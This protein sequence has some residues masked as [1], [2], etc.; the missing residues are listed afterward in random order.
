MLCA[1]WP[2][3]VQRLFPLPLTW[4]Y[5]WSCH[6]PRS[7]APFHRRGGTCTPLASN[8]H[9]STTS[10]SVLAR[11]S[12]SQGTNASPTHSGLPNAPIPLIYP[13][14]PFL[15][16][17]TDSVD[18]LYVEVR[19]WDRVS[20]DY[21]GSCSVD[22]TSVLLDQKKELKLTPK[23]EQAKKKL[24]SE[25]GRLGHIYLTIKRVHKVLR[26]CRCLVVVL[27][28][29]L[30]CGG[31]AAWSCGSRPPCIIQPI[32]RQDATFI[33]SAS[34]S[35]FSSATRSRSRLTAAP[36]GVAPASSRWTS[37]RERTSRPWTTT[38]CQT[39]T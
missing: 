16:P 35:L 26:W 6:P 39:H 29:S 38:G 18:Q 1:E 36:K 19:D 17:P 25:D 30:P 24:P 4:I 32:W 8:A 22:V 28:H 5:R 11:H 31:I 20:T 27:Q 7:R 10:I 2:R 23:N 13:P 21:M 34:P 12:L 33:S 15:N 3:L 14:S 9:S 37:S